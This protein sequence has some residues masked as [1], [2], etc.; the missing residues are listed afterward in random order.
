[1]NIYILYSVIVVQCTM[2]Y[3]V[4][5]IINYYKVKMKNTSEWHAVISCYYNYWKL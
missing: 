3:L 4:W 2:I 1:M 5:H